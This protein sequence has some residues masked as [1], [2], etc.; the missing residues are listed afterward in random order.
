MVNMRP[1]PL[2]SDN[3]YDDDTDPLLEESNLGGSSKT[4]A[5][6][7]KEPPV[8]EGQPNSDVKRWLELMEDFMSCFSENE[9]MK[10][11]KVM[12]Y[13]GE[14]PRI[15]VKT[16]EQEAKSEKRPFLWED[17]KK[18]LLE[19]FLPTI[20]EE[21]ARAR[22]ASLKQTGSV[23]EYT[24]EF[25]K[26]DRYIPNSA[27]ADRIDRYKRGL[28]ERIQ[29]LWLQQTTLQSAVRAS[30]NNGTPP[31]RP[32]SKL[33]E[34]IAYAAQ[35]EGSLEQY[36]EL[37]KAAYRNYPSTAA[38]RPFYGSYHQGENRRKLAG[39]NQVMITDGHGSDVD[40]MDPDLMWDGR[41]NHQVGVGGLNQVNVALPPF[42]KPRPVKPHGMS[43]EKY[44]RLMKEKKCLVCEQAGHRR[45]DCPKVQASSANAGSDGSTSANPSSKAPKKEDAP[46]Q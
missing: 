31:I 28:K 3:E 15:Y 24:L 11:Q 39:V 40:S 45:A 29:Q 12:L 13:L 10:V 35:L 43:E 21:I 4:T 16:A 18:I 17:V 22:L 1:S 23:A 33:S 42:K 20:T 26:L 27:A 8:F 38:Y 14:G 36:R 25:Q 44:E 2:G 34:A 6:K 30:V 41:H 32:I 9:V 19:C 37:T 5:M 46:R 7:V